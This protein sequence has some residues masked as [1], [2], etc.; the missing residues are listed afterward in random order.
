MALVNWSTVCRP[1]RLGDLGVLD[2]QRFSRALRLRWKWLDW[3]DKECPWAGTEIPGDKDDVA[4]FSASTTVAIG[5]GLTANFWNDRWLDGHV[6]RLLALDIFSPCSR[7]NISVNDAIS[8]N[9]WLRGLHRISDI[10][11]LRQF[12]LLW[13][14][15]QQAVDCEGGSQVQIL[16]VAVA[17]RPDPYGQQPCI[18][19]IPHDDICCFCDQADETPTHLILTCPFARCVW[20][21]VGNILGLPALATNAQTATSI[22]HWWDDLT[23]CLERRAKKVAIYTVWNIWKER[24]R[25]VFEHHSLQEAAILYLIKQ[26]LSL[27]SVSASWLS[28]VENEPEP[29][30]D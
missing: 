10:S 20:T 3:T 24:N 29:E 19:G 6:P 27:P 5:N 21:M 14:Q 13:N 1:K 15:L 4:L 16:H 25:R 2:L 30:P 28:D 17:A 9:K 12:A 22:E 23:S 26:D 11:Q 8:N 18:R 7:K